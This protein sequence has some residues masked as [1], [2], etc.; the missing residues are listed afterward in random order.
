MAEVADSMSPELLSSSDPDFDFDSVDD[1]EIHDQGFHDIDDNDDDVEITGISSDSDEEI[2]DVNSDLESTVS[3]EDP[4]DLVQHLPDFFDDGFEEG[5]LFVDDFYGQGRNEQQLA[6]PQSP[7]HLRNRNL[8]SPVYEDLHHVYRSISPP[9]YNNNYNNLD[10]SLFPARMDAG[11][12][13]GHQR[14]ELVGMEVQGQGNARDHR[15]N[16][17]PQPDVIDLTGDD[18][19]P[20]P[21]QPA[22]SRQLSQNAR[23]RRSQQRSTPPRLARSDANY[24]GGHAVISLLSSDSEG[25]EPVAVPAARQHG[26]NNGA[27]RGAR[28]A[29]PG[30]QQQPAGRAQAQPPNMHALGSLH[31]NFQQNFQQMLHQIPNLPIF[32]IF[33]AAMVG[34][35]DDDDIVVVAEN[36]RAPGHHPPAPAHV[37][38]RPVHLNY[39]AHPFGIGRGGAGVN[40]KPAH[41]PPKETTV[42]FTRDTG[43]EVVAICASCEQELAFDP[44]GE[45]DGPATPAKKQRSKKDKAEHHFWAVKACGHVYCKKCYDNRK[46]AARNPVPV[47][48]RPE[49]SGAKNKMMCAVDGCDSEVSSK[50]AWVGLF[51]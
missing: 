20:G 27:G 18:S 45:D 15:H 6:V 50:T 2:T 22:P 35:G 36:N 43:D 23:R 11:G 39:N 25:D 46:P 8:L 5:G 49:P 48:F 29:R 33:G 40:P 4:H 14:D 37:P 21:G 38:L 30:P 1:E 13:A 26:N 32:S 51:L 12:G 24:M 41:Q 7:R 3:P 16:G 44:D 10:H 19:P 9:N 47:S 31:Q 17:R 42:G 34:Q 28:N